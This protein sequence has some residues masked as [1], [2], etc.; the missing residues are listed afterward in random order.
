MMVIKV[1]N[2]GIL[3]ITNIEKKNKT[4]NYQYEIDGAWEKI[5]V[6]DNNLFLEYNV[7]IESV[8]DHIAII[9]LITNL[10]PIAFVFDLTITVESLDKRFYESVSKI[11]NGYQ[12]MYNNWKMGGTIKVKNLIETN[13]DTNGALLLFSGGVDAFN[14]FYNHIDENPFLLTLWGADVS[15]NDTN[16]WKNVINHTKKTSET[17]GLDYGY[18]KTNFKSFINDKFLSKFITEK[19]TK[20]HGDSWYHEFQHGIGIIGHSAPLAYLYNKKYIYIASSY[21]GQ[22]KGKYTCASDPTID[23]MLCFGNCSTIHDG[24][25]YTRQQKIANIC[26]STEKYNNSISLRVCWESTGGKNCSA[27]EKCSRTILGIITEKKNPNDFG[28]EFNEHN[29]KKII[30][31]LKKFAKYNFVFAYKDIQNRFKENYKY[32]EVP[33]DLKW[34]YNLKI[35]DKKPKIISFKD[36]IINKIKRI[37]L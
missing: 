10:L 26:S 36:L 4:I 27:C 37:F 21:T 32:E 9:P 34:F 29:R 15:L 3:N 25:E 23:N 24:Y 6:K 11:R 1:N 28:F 20:H 8:P 35:K 5:A 12:K 22:Y 33:D 13:N 31:L 7:N 18:C 30:N 2:T 16:G 17:F 14:T 19:I